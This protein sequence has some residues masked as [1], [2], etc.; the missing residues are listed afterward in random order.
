MECD[1]KLLCHGSVQVAKLRESQ[2]WLE[3][4]VNAPEV[5]VAMPM[6]SR[7]PVR[8]LSI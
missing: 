8:H 3:R 1:N 7:A 5:A 6:A 2:D 4:Q